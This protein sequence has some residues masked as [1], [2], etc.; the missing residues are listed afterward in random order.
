MLLNLVS[1]NCESRAAGSGVF[2]VIRD[3]AIE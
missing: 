1:V 3:Y 2:G